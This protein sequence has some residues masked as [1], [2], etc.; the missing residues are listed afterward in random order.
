MK[1]NMKDI[2][3]IQ[4]YE[5]IRYNG[6]GCYFVIENEQDVFLLDEIITKF[7][8]FPRVGGC[9]E[10]YIEILNPNINV[11]INPEFLTN[12]ILSRF[13][14]ISLH[15]Y[16]V[17]KLDTIMEIS[18]DVLKK[19]RTVMFE[20]NKAS[21]FAK[22]GYTPGVYMIPVGDFEFDIDLTGMKFGHLDLKHVDPAIISKILDQIDAADEVQILAENIKLILPDTNIGL[23]YIQNSDI[24]GYEASHDGQNL[25][26]NPN[27]KKLVCL[28]NLH[29]NF[30]HNYTLL[31]YRGNSEY[32][33]GIVARNRQCLHDSR[34]KSTKPA[35]SL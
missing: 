18:K 33:H 29:G 14:K 2:S 1:F 9:T 22:I 30:D 34:F 24:Y 23:V 17:F 4:E 21:D 16:P 31:K 13:K 10:R 7:G 27:I 11:R 20:S 32:I 25:A 3:T 6:L 28:Y 35:K 19:T 5:K 26:D 15:T 8:I 12:P